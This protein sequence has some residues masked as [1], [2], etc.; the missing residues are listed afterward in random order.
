MS[1]PVSSTQSTAQ[2]LSMLGLWNFISQCI[3]GACQP[4]ERRRREE[5]KNKKKKIQTSMAETMNHL[6]SAL[7]GC[8][9]NSVDN[10]LEAD[11]ISGL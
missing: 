10:I 1:F 5:V 9:V 4:N 6:G 11:L 7:Q 3:V 2:E 8:S